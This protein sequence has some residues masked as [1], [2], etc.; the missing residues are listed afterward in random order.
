MRKAEDGTLLA[1]GELQP[2]RYEATL[3][4][5]LRRRAAHRAGGRKN[6]IARQSLMTRARGSQRLPLPGPLRRRSA[7]EAFNARGWVDDEVL[8]GY[9]VMPRLRASLCVTT[10]VSSKGVEALVA[11]TKLEVYHHPYFLVIVRHLPRARI[12][13][14]R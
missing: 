3:D 11:S 6:G 4:Y 2:A 9:T 14:S 7:R 12:R 1:R 8:Y 5:D 13:R 10:P